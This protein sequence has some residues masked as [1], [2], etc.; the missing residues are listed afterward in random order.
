MQRVH[1]FGTEAGVDVN[2]GVVAPERLPAGAEHA[3]KSV[4][5]VA[6]AG[7]CGSDRVG[8]LGDRAV[9]DRGDQ[10][11]ARGEVDVDGGPDDTGAA[12]DLGHAGVR[13]ARERVDGG[14]QDRDLAAVGVG[15]ATPTA[16]S[17][18]VVGGRHLSG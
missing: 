5:G 16:G 4:G 7:G 9:G 17:G 10:R 13:I 15:A 11:L 18:L 14:V 12:S 8:G 1:V 6:L 3:G 2:E